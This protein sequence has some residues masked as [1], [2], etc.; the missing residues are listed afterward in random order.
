MGLRILA[1][2]ERLAGLHALSAT[3]YRGP[4][5]EQVWALT[6]LQELTVN[7]SPLADL[8]PIRHLT[9][10]TSLHLLS[11][12]HLSDLSPLE[13]LPGLRR[14]T[15]YGCPEAD[16]AP[17]SRLPTLRQ[18]KLGPHAHDALTPTLM[19]RLTTLLLRQATL[20][21]PLA[22][23]ATALRALRLFGGSAIT[24][25]AP[26]AQLPALENLQLSGAQTLTDLAPMTGRPLR[27][28]SLFQLP[29]LCDLSALRGAPLEVLHLQRCEQLQDLALLVDLPTLRRLTLRRLGVPLAP[30]ALPALAALE[31][32]SIDATLLGSDGL[33][34]LAPLKQ[35]H[36]LALGGAL[37]PTTPMVTLP[38]LRHL[39]LTGTTAPPPLDRLA[40]VAPQ[41]E[42]LELHRTDT[43]DISA[44]PGFTTL[45]AL[46]LTE[47]ALHNLQPLAQMTALEQVHL[48]PHDEADLSPLLSMPQ[49]KTIYIPS[50]HPPGRALD[51]LSERGV[52]VRV[53]LSP[54]RR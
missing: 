44:L 2:R 28:I 45:K 33:R 43:T 48:S 31:E 15:L 35:L 37:L 23:A 3:A 4:P 26:L 22:A 42:L 12:P 16:P 7:R 8:S 38:Q 24:D 18:L 40:A 50:S 39:R 21:A 53:P 1:A 46:R 29:A 5:L 11:C 51:A 32:L 25:L 19:A 41:L 54:A 10:L 49:L 36:T 34:N 14:M 13:Q 6:G 9:E 17:L 47:P 30:P 20:P 27:L 52:T